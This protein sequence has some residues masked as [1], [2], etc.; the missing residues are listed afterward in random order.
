MVCVLGGV[1]WLSRAGV[2]PHGYFWEKRQAQSWCQVALGAL[3]DAL[4][5]L[6]HTILEGRASS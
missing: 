4:S 3:P 6:D 5:S 2:L 1:I